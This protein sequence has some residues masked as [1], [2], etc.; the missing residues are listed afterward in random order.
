MLSGA[1]AA[2]GVPECRSGEFR[3]LAVLASA[4]NALRTLGGSRGRSSVHQGEKRG[5]LPTPVG[6]EFMRYRL[7]DAWT[8]LGRSAKR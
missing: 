3:W 2:D 6:V 8:V 1:A 5:M 4:Q 7:L